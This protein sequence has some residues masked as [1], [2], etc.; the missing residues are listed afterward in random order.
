MA[1]YQQGK[2]GWV[3]Y[4]RPIRSHYYEAHDSVSICQTY[5]DSVSE[6]MAG[7]PPGDSCAHCLRAYRRTRPAA[8]TRGTHHG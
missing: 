2:A 5:G 7:G 3:R 1:S 8:A 4:D 6:R